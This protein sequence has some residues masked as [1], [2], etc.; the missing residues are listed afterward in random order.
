MLNKHHVTAHIC[1][2]I[3]CLFFLKED[4]ITVLIIQ[5]IKKRVPSELHNITYLSQIS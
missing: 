4:L 5:F 3:K 2:W 1:M